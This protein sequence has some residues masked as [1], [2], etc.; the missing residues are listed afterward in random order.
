M[1][2]LVSRST[3][4]IR[5]IK[6]RRASRCSNGSSSRSSIGSSKRAFGVFTLEEHDKMFPQLTWKQ[7]EFFSD[8][9]QRV[10]SR[11]GFKKLQLMNS[12]LCT[13]A[14]E[15]PETVAATQLA[16]QAYPLP[17]SNQMPLE[18]AILEPFGPDR[19][20][21]ESISTRNEPNPVPGR[22]ALQFLL[23]EIEAKGT[24][25]DLIDIYNQWY[26]A[27]GYV[28]P[29]GYD[30]F[31]EID[32][33]DACRDLDV[34]EIGHKE[35][36]YICSDVFDSDIV[37]LKNFPRHTNPFFNMKES[38]TDPGIFKKIDILGR[39]KL[40]GSGK[41]IAGSAERSCD[42]AKMRHMID[43]IVDG[44]YIAKLYELFGKERVE[45]ELSEYFSLQFVPRFG[46]GIS[47]TPRLVDNMMNSGM[48]PWENYN[49]D[50]HSALAQVIRKQYGVT[51]MYQALEMSARLRR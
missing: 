4:H 1:R 26:R 35:E 45:Q 42:V 44:K 49:P 30:K 10:F 12:G 13:A 40:S 19:A 15:D 36:A 39:S 38:E 33:E 28:P 16:G 17:Q 47:I 29:H 9:A 11:N 43:T 41:E 27:L 21:C 37:L 31:P 51:A 22:H 18:F 34:S 7:Y 50:E 24:F 48:A 25:K 14:C 20:W 23:F 8:V 32:Y 3:R 2:S 6:G 5:G 46:A